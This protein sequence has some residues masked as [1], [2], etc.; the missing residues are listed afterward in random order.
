MVRVLM[1]FFQV[2]ASASTVFARLRSCETAWQGSHGGALR[3][4]Q[5]CVHNGGCAPRRQLR[6]EQRDAHANGADALRH[7]G[8]VGRRQQRHREQVQQVAVDITITTA[9]QTWL[10]CG[11]SVGM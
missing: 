2:Q 9:R 4:P 7:G 3:P 10:S 6:L 5:E 1:F 8:A 11:C